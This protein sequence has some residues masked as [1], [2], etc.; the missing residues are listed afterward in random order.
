VAAY[1]P[2]EPRVA[3][4]AALAALM[5]ETTCGAETTGRNGEFTPV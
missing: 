3:C 1:D 5:R 2:N 4:Q